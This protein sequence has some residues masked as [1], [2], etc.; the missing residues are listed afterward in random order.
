MPPQETDPLDAAIGGIKSKTV[1]ETLRARASG[2][3]EDD[4]LRILRLAQDIRA[5]QGGIS[6]PVVAVGVAGLAL[7]IWFLSTTS[8][9]SALTDVSAGRPILMLIV[10]LT[11]VVF[12]GMMLNAALFGSPSDDAAERFQ[13]GREVFLV[14]SGICATVV[15]FYFGSGTA[16]APRPGDA[17]MHAS[18]GADGTI[19]ATV[20]GGA[21]PH[22]VALLKD[23]ESFPFTADAD[24]SN[25]FTLA[26]DPA[27]CPVDGNYQVTGTHAYPPVAVTF[28]SDELASASWTQC[29]EGEGE[30][31]E[32]DGGAAGEAGDE[33]PAETPAATAG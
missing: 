24:D 9:S 2:A 19:T 16:N 25:K 28:S 27:L 14:F 13:R 29:G 8:D 7:L 1:Q 4:K 30:A 12:G 17:S 18:L 15:G 22:T 11:T 3:T 33:P 6:W 32:G 5:G 21:P 31:A 26:V 10:I 23:G 20:V